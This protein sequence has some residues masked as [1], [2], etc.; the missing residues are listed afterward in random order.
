MRRGRPAVALGD[1]AEGGDAKAAEMFETQ[2]STYFVDSFIR[3]HRPETFLG[4]I[5]HFVPDK[6]DMVMSRG[7]R[8]ALEAGVEVCI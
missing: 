6:V 7:M 5:G 1:T 3:K 2:Q 8:T 4:E